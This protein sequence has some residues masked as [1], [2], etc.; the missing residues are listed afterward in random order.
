[1]GR[2]G[3]VKKKEILYCPADWET[4]PNSDK[5]LQEQKPTAEI[6]NMIKKGSNRIKSI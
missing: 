4:C 1:M 6:N 3:G 2:G 5:I